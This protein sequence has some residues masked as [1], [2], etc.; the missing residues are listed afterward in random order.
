[1]KEQSDETMLGLGL[2]ALS[3]MIE[4]IDLN[5]YGKGSKAVADARKTRDDI[6]AWLQRLKSS[7]GD[8]Q[9]RADDGDVKVGYDN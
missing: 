9:V 6:Q 5:G 1:M 4:F 3:E 2:Q 7:A 8:L